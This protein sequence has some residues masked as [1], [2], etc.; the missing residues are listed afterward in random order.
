[1]VRAAPAMP[2]ASS[3]RSALRRSALGTPRQ[4][5][6]RKPLEAKVARVSDAPVKSSPYQMY[7][8]EAASVISTYRR[9][10]A[11]LEAPAHLWRRQ[12]PLRPGWPAR[13]DAGFSRQ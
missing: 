6:A 4:S 7:F 12:A 5:S 8:N 1:M 3:D 13:P 10:R 11:L 9:M 2:S